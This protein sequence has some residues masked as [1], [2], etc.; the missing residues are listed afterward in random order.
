MSKTPVCPNSG[1]NRPVSSRGFYKIHGIERP[2]EN[3]LRARRSAG[4]DA[5]VAETLQFP[6]TILHIQC[7]I[8][9]KSAMMGIR[10]TE[11]S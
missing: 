4:R 6:L 10:L 1:E 3:A 5:F 2:A 8:A 9:R 7:T 11:R